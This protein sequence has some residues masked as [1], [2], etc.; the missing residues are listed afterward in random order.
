M[1]RQ[2][3]L[4]LSQQK[5]LRKWMET[6][7][8]AAKLTNRFIAGLTLEDELAA[9]ARLAENKVFSTLDHLGENV[10][11]LAEAAAS[12]ES[13]LAALD[14][15][16]ERALPATV[17]I[18]LTQFGLDFSTDAC[19]ENAMALAK[20]ATERGTR[21]EI[22][23]ES[24][25]YTDRTLEIVEKV[26]TARAVIQAY[27][28]RSQKDI[29]RL[30][31]LKIPV[32]LCKGAYKEPESLAYPKKID[33]DRNF[34]ALMKLLL[35]KGTYPAIA[36]HDENILGEAF[37][38]ARERK[39]PPE[40]FEFQMLHGI[41]TDLQRRVIDLGYRMRVYVPYGT[42]W[43]PYFMRRLAERPANVVF[44]AKNFFKPHK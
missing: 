16:G 10:S 43:Y 4:F 19:L 21:I 30:N 26:G 9:C 31:A 24:T 25:D 3:F 22:D 42:A 6:S 33:V 32:R 36:S 2:T 38:Y 5:G 37:R 29:E 14:A 11:S 18:K 35:D 44:L 12:R 17:S 7:P 15:I 8:T 40:N 34:I 41:R 13:Y 27:L 23:M 28:Y 39:I 20:R 1:M